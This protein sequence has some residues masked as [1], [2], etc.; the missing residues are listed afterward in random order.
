MQVTHIINELLDRMGYNEASIK[1]EESMGRIKVDVT[2]PE[3]RE[4]IGEKGTT[5]IMFEHVLRRIISRRVVP[6]PK[7]DIDINN[8]KKMREGVLRDFALDIGGRVRADKSIVELDPMPSFDRRIIHLTLANF[9]DI[10]TES[11]GEGDS[12]YVV[13]K[14]L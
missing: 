1:T 6:P 5:L 3:A 8:Y 4:L 2:L 14:P 7:V 13:I 9:S 10:T 11:M 12:R